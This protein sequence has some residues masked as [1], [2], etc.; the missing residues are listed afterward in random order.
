MDSL[1]GYFVP[2]RVQYSAAGIHYIPSSVGVIRG[3]HGLASRLFCPVPCTLQ[4]CR[5]TL[6]PIISWCV[7]RRAWTRFQALLSCTVQRCRNTLYPIIS[8]C[9]Q[10]RAW[11]RFQALVLSCTVYTIQRFLADDVPLP[12]DSPSSGRDLSVRSENGKTTCYDFTYTKLRL[13]V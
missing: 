11:T 2:F 4:R 1:P 9:D 12:A 5:N 7:Q 3:E 13:N 10:W 8:W 6:Y